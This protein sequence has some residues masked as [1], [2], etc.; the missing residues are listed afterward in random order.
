LIANIYLFTGCAVIPLGP[1]FSC[2]EVLDFIVKLK[3]TAVLGMPSLVMTLVEHVAQR[4]GAARASGVVDDT[5]DIVI[6]K[7]IT[8][9]VL[10]AK[11]LVLLLLLLL[12]LLFS[13]HIE[14]IVEFNCL[15]HL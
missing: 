14:I 7:V 5:A 13:T 10:C 6:S 1:T 12:L 2:D 3:P 9:K 4:R 8:G 15:L 11:V